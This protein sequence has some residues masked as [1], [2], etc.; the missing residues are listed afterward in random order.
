ML[1]RGRLALFSLTLQARLMTTSA[2][3]A[4]ASPPV[5]ARVALVSDVQYAREADADNYVG[6]RRRHYRHSLEV[7]KRAVAWF[8][9]PLPAGP[10]IGVA[11]QLG[12][13]LD[14]KAHADGAASTALAMGDV[15][16]VLEGGDLGRRQ[17]W[18][19][20]VGNHELY[21]YKRAALRRMPMYYDA[22]AGGS[23]GSDGSGDEEALH[24]RM[25]LGGGWRA[26]MLD[27]FADSIMDPVG[28]PA[29]VARAT[30]YLA[31]K[32]GR[33]VRRAVFAVA[34][35]NSS[36]TVVRRAVA[37]GR[38]AHRPPAPTQ[39]PNIDPDNP[40]V[41]ADWT[42]DLDPLQRRY[43]PYNGGL[44]PAQRAWLEAELAAAAAA[45][46]RVLVF[47]HLPCFSACSRANNILWDAELVHDLLRKAGPR[48]VAAFVAGHDHDGGYAVDED[49]VHH[50]VPR[51]PLEVDEGDDAFGRLDLFDDRIDVTWRGKAPRE[52][53]PADGFVDARRQGWPASLELVQ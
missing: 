3:A 46:E 39:N 48:V 17:R 15:V 19:A 6:S 24:Y 34:A 53:D 50:L 9:A 22:A 37:A 52:P 10:P 14:F 2:L 27:A 25:D 41:S 33:A 40:L 31:D 7:L 45:R 20:C 23:G 5:R 38:L 36:R 44:G 51:A 28:G 11:V 42:K 30:R 43:V 35:A 4:P 18:R 16:K 8:D 49:G 29:A 21:N 26:V 32:V 13:L 12:D 1:H 47:C